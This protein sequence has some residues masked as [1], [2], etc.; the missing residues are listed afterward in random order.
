M[1]VRLKW[2][3]GSV[4]AVVD[5]GAQEEFLNRCA[6]MGARLWT[7]D[8]CGTG[9]L[10]VE[11][12]AR[13]AP[14]LCQ[15]AREAGCR[16]SRI[17]RRGLPVLLRGL[18][19]R[20][21]LL[22]GATLCLV[23]LATGSHVILSVEVTGNET[24]PDTV[25]LSQLRLCGAGF[26]TWGPSVDIRTVENRMLRRMDSLAFFS[27]EL[28]G[29]RAV[30]TVREADPPPEMD[31]NRQPADVIAAA[32]GIVTQ[33]EPW[34]GDACFREGDA[35]LEGEVLISGHVVLDPPALIQ[36]DLGSMEVRAE[37]IVMAR[38]R[39]ML[40]AEI[41]LTAEGKDYTGREQIR[42]SLGLMGRR[43]NFFENSGIPYE[44]YDTITYYKSW[45]P[46]KGALPV[47]WEKEVIR[48]YTPVTR[49]L[50][51]SRGEELLKDRLTRALEAAMDQGTLLKSDWRTDRTG[52]R[53]TVSLLAQ[54]TE[55]IG[56]VRERTSAEKESPPN[57][58]KEQSEAQDPNDRTDSEY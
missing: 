38:T 26:G 2:L 43:M 40:S 47:V 25:I 12:S 44:K 1:R 5:G 23:G 13:D 46:P 42:Y 50:D 45:T 39:R 20:R 10:K 29:T 31:G 30:A 16:L 7:M 14:L 33:M 36:G 17:R 56:R 22:L 6:A 11:A 3:F 35:V 24:I 28:H 53:L 41:M 19:R 18:R 15:A 58:T 32:S 55:Q 21:G 34:S 9:T 54:C 37:G 49:R 48:E 52:E 57:D 27:L 8:R 4:S 51:P